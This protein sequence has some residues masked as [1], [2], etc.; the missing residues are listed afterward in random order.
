MNLNRAVIGTVALWT[1]VAGGH[2]IPRSIRARAVNSSVCTVD[3]RESAVEASPV[4]MSC[5]NFGAGKASPAGTTSRIAVGKI[6][7]TGA[8]GRI[9]LGR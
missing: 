5:R 8:L 6:R 7:L 4:E 1:L 9:S 2:A 3:A